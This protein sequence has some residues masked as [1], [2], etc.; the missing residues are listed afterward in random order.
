MDQSIL[1]NATLVQNNIRPA[2]LLQ[3]INF[4]E[5]TINKREKTNLILEEL[6]DKFPELLQT[7]CS[8]GIILSKKQY[9]NEA[10][11]CERLGEIIGYPSCK[12]YEYIT[13]HPDEIYTIFELHAQTSGQDS[14]QLLANCCKHENIKRDRLVFKNMA[15]KANTILKDTNLGDIIVIETDTITITTLINK[16]LNNQSLNNQENFEV[17]NHIWNLGME[18]LNEYSFD[19]SNPIHKGIVLTLLSYCNN[20]TLSPFYPLQKYPKE[21]EEV[22]K[23]TGKWETEMLRILDSL[24]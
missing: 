1:I 6:K 12:E 14:I 21:M 7:E 16:L 24:N 22:N 17:N 5:Y 18:K 9:L 20:T 13:E 19:Y 11:T 10:I 3:S 15:E 8:Q 2:F 4:G 23:I